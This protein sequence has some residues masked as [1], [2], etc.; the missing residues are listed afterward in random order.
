MFEDDTWPTQ[1]RED[2][3]NFNIYLDRARDMLRPTPYKEKV[4][5]AKQLEKVADDLVKNGLPD[6]E[7]MASVFN[8]MKM[9]RKQEFFYKVPLYVQLFPFLK[10]QF[11]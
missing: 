8:R 1:F 7:D 9:K 2:L 5:K 6:I 10:M 3:S 11:F 4:H